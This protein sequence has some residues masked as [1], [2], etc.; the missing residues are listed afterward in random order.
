MKENIGKNEI[1]IKNGRC[2]MTPAVLICSILN[3]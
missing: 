1:L 3:M 2:H